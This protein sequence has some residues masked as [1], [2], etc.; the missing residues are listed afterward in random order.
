MQGGRLALMAAV[1]NVPAV[2]NAA[3]YFVDRNVE[4]GRGGTTAIE[5]GNRILSYEDVRL[6]VNR[7]GNV[8]R[9]LGVRIEDRVTLVLPDSPEFVAAFFGAIKVGAVAVP[10]N[11]SLRPADYAYMLDDS[12]AGVLLTATS[13]WPSIEPIASDATWLH[14]VALVDDATAGLPDAGGKRVVDLTQVMSAASSELDA[15]PTSRDD[16]AFWLYSSGTTGFPKGTIHLQH[17]MVFCCDHYGS[18]V[19]GIETHDRTFSVAKLFFAY[20][21]G[22]ALY[23]PFFVG[24]TTILHPAR[25]VPETVLEL[26]A[27]TKPTLFF[28]VPTAYAAM[29]DVPNTERFDLSS[30]RY[31]ISAGESLPAEIF[32]RWKQ[33][34]GFEILDGIGT[35]EA[36]HMFISNAPGA[37]RPGSSGRAVDGYD[38]RLVDDLDRDVPVGEIGRLRVAGDSIAAGYWNKHEKTKAAFLGPWL[39]TGDSYRVDEDGFYWHAGRSDDMLKV[40]GQWVSP[41]EVENTL[42][43]HG[44]VLECAVV[45]LED[46]SGLIKPVAYVV[47]RRGVEAS[48]ELASTLQEFVKE[49]IA[50]FKYPRQI[51][52]IDELPKTA[53][54]KIQRYKLRTKT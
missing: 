43:A 36:C 50:P 45:G 30:V 16:A 28:A 5:A 37:I 27:R 52:F 17:D 3:S 34:F 20:G 22:N 19:L 13:L 35:T 38:V 33:T 18:H 9:E 39:D 7:C 24:A 1:T 8:L 6:L 14:T 53:T 49:K 25:F 2:F 4:R 29:L 40:G 31:G 11:T 48:P 54:G 26:C 23:F 10:T 32:R 15:A 12:R 46:T 47:V 21:L 41:V 51:H 42:V 44:A